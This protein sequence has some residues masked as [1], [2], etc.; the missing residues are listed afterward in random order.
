MESNNQQYL[1]KINE[2]LK[3]KEEWKLTILQENLFLATTKIVA[4]NQLSLE[5]HFLQ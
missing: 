3:E 1:L 4:K 2:L 5:N